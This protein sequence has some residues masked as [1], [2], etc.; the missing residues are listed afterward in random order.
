MLYVHQ[1]ASIPADV[2]SKIALV[3]RGGC[4]FNDKIALLKA[5]GKL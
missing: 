5:A 4:T 1:A 3:M 2:S